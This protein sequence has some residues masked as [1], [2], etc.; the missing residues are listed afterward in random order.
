MP[1]SPDPRDYGF[2]MVEVTA[3]DSQ[4]GVARYRFVLSPTARALYNADV[5][6]RMQWQGLM[7]AF[8][9]QFLAMHP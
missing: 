9:K 8:D 2:K 7:E 3:D 6:H 1:A 4:K 5:V